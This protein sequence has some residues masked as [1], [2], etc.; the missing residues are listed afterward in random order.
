M[1]VEIQYAAYVYQF[2]YAPAQPGHLIS[3]AKKNGVKIKFTGLN[4]FHFELHWSELW[5]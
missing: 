2:G 1:S 5:I 3:F 4:F